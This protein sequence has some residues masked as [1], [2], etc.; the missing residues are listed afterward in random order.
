MATQFD[1][2]PASGNANADHQTPVFFTGDAREY[3]G[4]WIVNILLTIVTLGI[5][6]AWAT[7]RTK[8]YFANN[9]Q[10]NGTGFDYLANPVSLLKGRLLAVVV[11]VAYVFLSKI[12]QVIGGALLVLLGLAMP[13]LIVQ[14]TKFN[15]YNTSYRGLRF[16]FTGTV[17][18]AMLVYLGLPF[19]FV[20][21]AGLILPYY[22]YRSY[23]YRV[24]HTRFGT[25]SFVPRLSV[26]SFYLVY[27]E[28]LG[29]F[30]A[31]AGVLIVLIWMTSFGLGISA[32]PVLA[33]LPLAI[34][35]FFFYAARPFLT[36][37]L[38]NLVYNATQLDQLSF[39]CDLRA[40]DLIWLQAS[41]LV[42]IFI[43]LGM[44]IPW[45]KIRTARYLADHMSL[46]SSALLD[47]YV[48]DKQEKLNAAGEEIAEIFDI[49]APIFN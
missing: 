8:K 9:T 16:G 29:L 27:L 11:Y 6:S 7:V 13:W 39:Y 43:S 22:S 42:A 12:N 44:L 21:T 17:R 48:A 45:T 23:K 34:V 33:M 46:S 4:I 31:A 15:L 35:A 26:K 28:L 49:D 32:S 24:E 47:D 14:S 37:R 10:I 41:N 25:S 19:L 30:M 5:Y 18:E 1:Q 36:A 20:F 40:R 3:F 2:Q 38:N